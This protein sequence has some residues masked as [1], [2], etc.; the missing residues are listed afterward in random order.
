MLVADG[1]GGPAGV[2]RRQAKV[3]RNAVN[4]TLRQ[5][6]IKYKWKADRIWSFHGIKHAVVRTCVSR[7]TSHCRKL[8]NMLGCGARLFGACRVA[9]QTKRRTTETVQRARWGTVTLLTVTPM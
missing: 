8:W 4:E 6:A 3:G 7:T 9:M 2:S 5:A 1:G